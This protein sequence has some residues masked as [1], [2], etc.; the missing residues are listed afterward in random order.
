MGQ[1]K[2][3]KQ[4]IVLL[5]QSAVLHNQALALLKGTALLKAT[6]APIIPP[7]AVLHDTWRT[8][9]RWYESFGPPPLCHR[10]NGPAV[11]VRKT[12]EQRWVL[13]NEAVTIEAKA[14]FKAHR[15]PRDYYKWEQIHHNIFGHAGGLEG[16]IV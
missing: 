7:G 8:Q 1:A 3:N 5:N 15:I 10:N 14:W 16:I 6:P 9:E 13:H 4:A 12:N 11:T 2:H